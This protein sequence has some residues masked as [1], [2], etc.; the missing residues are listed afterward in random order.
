MHLHI[1]R[2][3]VAAT[4]LSSLVFCASSVVLA[5]KPR[6]QQQPPERRE[7]DDT[8]TVEGVV[9]NAVQMMSS[10]SE[11]WA[12]QVLPGQSKVTIEG[13]AEPSFLRGGVNIRFDG[14]VD[15]K[16]ALQGE[17][18]ELEVYTPQGKTDAGLF[19][20]GA[21]E[22]AKPIAKLVAGS[23][24]IKGRITSLKENQIM[25]V[26]AGK[27]ISGTLAATPAIKVSSSDLGYAQKGD[28]IKVKGWYTEGSKYDPMKNRPGAVLAQEVTVTMSE[29]LVGK[30]KATRP[31]KAKAKAPGSETEPVNDLFGV[32]S[33]K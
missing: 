12:V 26:A 14:E 8:G 33:K 6:Q 10:K 24:T 13:T 28:V 17:I 18:A 16:G 29:P 32:G 4:L 19:P 15:A 9:G 22:Q 5:Q 2:P 25:V 7:W 20:Q 1:F 30:K 3:I 21:D 23:Y 11:P 31:V 27:K